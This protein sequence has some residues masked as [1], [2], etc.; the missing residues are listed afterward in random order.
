MSASKPIESLTP[1]S[2][3]VSYIMDQVDE[4]INCI[5]WKTVRFNVDKIVDG[6]G[7]EF[8]R[9]VPCEKCRH[10]KIVDDVYDPDTFDEYPQYGCS[11]LTWR[12]ND[13][14]EIPF[15]GDYCSWAET[16]DETA[17]KFKVTVEITDGHGNVL[18]SY[19]R[20]V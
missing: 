10:F 16:E 20:D 1:Q 3:F 19:E 4:G 14:D 18:Y 13:G 11:K 8:I 5:E 15:C 17:G 7:Q 9:I 6:A 12:C 2:A